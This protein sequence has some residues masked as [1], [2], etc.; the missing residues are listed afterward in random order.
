MLVRLHPAFRGTIAFRNPRFKIVGVPVS[1]VFEALHRKY[2]YFT[3]PWSR[4]VALSPR[5]G[6][7]Q[8]CAFLAKKREVAV[9]LDT[10]ER[11][12]LRFLLWYHLVSLSFTKNRVPPLYCTARWKSLLNP[13]WSHRMAATR[14]EA[15]PRQHKQTST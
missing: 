4:L 14:S 12:A 3:A 1:P 15:L 8:T 5:S 10:L 13:I 9:D 2:S 6:I 11:N 7:R